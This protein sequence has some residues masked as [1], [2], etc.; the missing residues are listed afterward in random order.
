[1]ILVVA[2]RAA[3]QIFSVWRELDAAEGL[4]PLASEL[5]FV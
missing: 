5:T 2:Q 4:E 3:M 1:M